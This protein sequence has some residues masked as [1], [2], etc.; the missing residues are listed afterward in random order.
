MYK[1]I[2]NFVNFL[3]NK[4]LTGFNKIKAKGLRF[5][6]RLTFFLAGVGISFSLF[7]LHFLSYIKK[8]DED[9]T[10]QIEEIKMVIVSQNN[11]QNMTYDGKLEY[12]TK[13]S[14]ENVA[15]IGHENKNTNK[16]EQSTID[17]SA[18]NKNTKI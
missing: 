13:A 6:G 8:S 1:L 18:P 4:Q 7:N 5:G 14:H 2:I 17:F 11:R 15:K 10:K 12:S 16:K 3:V 9:L